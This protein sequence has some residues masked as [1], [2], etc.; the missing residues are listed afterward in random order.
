M[1]GTFHTT[2]F[3]AMVALVLMLGACSSSDDSA[4]TPEE[5][6]TTTVTTTTT[7]PTT[8]TVAAADTEDEAS[9]ATL[10]PDATPLTTQFEPLE[11]GVYRVD[12]LGTPFTFEASDS[13][14]VL[15]N[16]ATFFVVGD[17]DSQGPD[18][19]DVV[20]LRVSDL[21][22]PTQPASEPEDQQAWPANDIDGWLDAVVD[23]VVISNRTETTVGE[24]SAVQFDMQLSDDAQCGEN[25]CVGFFT[26]RRVH[27]KSLEPGAMYRIWWID[28]GA[29]S[30]IAISAGIRTD[31][32]LGWFD[33]ADSIVGSVAFGD[34]S[35]NPIA[36][37]GDVWT[38]GFS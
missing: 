25:F 10:D 37:E 6:T 12:T 4:T 7:E 20:F 38:L 28:Q 36:P 21:S 26:N 34:T 31:S 14:F 13:L 17:P 24:R 2:V 27:S 23:D 29:E 8:T 30:P 22:D 15:P 18:D 16:N 19:R 9:P 32:Q 35:P 1:P 33:T 3:G 5:S 11:N